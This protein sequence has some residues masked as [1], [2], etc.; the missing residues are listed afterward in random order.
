MYLSSQIKFN[1]LI[2]VNSASFTGSYIAFGSFTY[3]VRL[4]HIVNNSDQNITISFDGGT[5]DHLFITASSFLVY[6]FGTNRGNSAPALEL[7]PTGMVVKGSAGTG[8]VYCMSAAAFS[9]RPT[10]GGTS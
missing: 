9:Q 2:S 4:L 10:F 3:P 5:T 1:P 8:L 7:P 6:D